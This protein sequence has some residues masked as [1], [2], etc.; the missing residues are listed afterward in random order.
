MNRK[1]QIISA[2]AAS[3]LAF[4]ALSQD[5]SNPQ[6]DSTRLEVTQTTTSSLN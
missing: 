2:S 5:T 1:L 3:I 4:S 6:A